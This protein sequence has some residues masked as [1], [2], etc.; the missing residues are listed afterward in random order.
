MQDGIA[1]VIAFKFSNEDDCFITFFL[2][3]VAELGRVLRKETG[4][5]LVPVGNPIWVCFLASS[6]LMF[7]RNEFG[8]AVV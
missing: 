8:D 6:V 5:L 1:G 3:F 7:L 4:T 2:E